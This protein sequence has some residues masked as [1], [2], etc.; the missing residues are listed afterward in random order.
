MTP[1][2]WLIGAAIQVKHERGRNSKKRGE[3]KKKFSRK[4]QGSREAP[5]PE[6]RTSPPKIQARTIAKKIWGE[7]RRDPLPEKAEKKCKWPN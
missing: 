7:K 3:I 5:K 4:K 1:K 6:A 2:N